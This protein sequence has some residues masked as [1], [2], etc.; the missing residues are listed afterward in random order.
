KGEAEREAGLHDGRR[1]RKGEILARDEVRQAVLT[2]PGQARDQPPVA[3]RHDPGEGD[4][5]ACRQEPEQRDANGGAPD[6]VGSK[7]AHVYSQAGWQALR[8]EGLRLVTPSASWSAV[9]CGETAR[10]GSLS[11]RK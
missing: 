9:V 4:G 11:G 3:I 2:L 6:R 8:P 1:Q 10:I 5:G 7:N